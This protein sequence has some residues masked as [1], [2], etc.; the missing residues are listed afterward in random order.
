MLIIFFDIKEIAYKKFILAGQR[1]Y[2]AYYCE[3]LLRMLENFDPNF[4]G[5]R[6]GCY[7]M[8]TQSL[9]FPFSPKIT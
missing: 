7:I 8:T 1:V 6:T 2:S 9:T 4:G 5:K 3:V